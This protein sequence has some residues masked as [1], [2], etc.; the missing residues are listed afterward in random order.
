VVVAAG[1]AGRRKPIL[2]PISR[3]V[4]RSGAGQERMR[5]V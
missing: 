1:I 3:Q 2:C 4:D 5:N